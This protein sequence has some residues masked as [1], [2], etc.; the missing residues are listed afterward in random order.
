MKAKKLMQDSIRARFSAAAPT[1][2][3]HAVIQRRVAGRLTTFLDDIPQPDTILEAGCG[4]G[5]LTEMLMRVF[6]TARIDALDISEG[7]INEAR[8]R[9]PDQSRIRWIVGDVRNFQ[10]AGQY[11]LVVSSSSLH[12]AEPLIETLLSLRH[13]LAPKGIL[14]AAIMLRGTLEEL[15]SARRIIAP[16][17]APSAQLMYFHD[18]AET[19]KCAGFSIINRQEETYKAEYAS[20]IEFLQCIHD[21][22]LTGGP[23][24]RS[25]TPLSRQELAALIDEY[26]M[27]YALG[28]GGV[29]A[30]Y[31]VGYF[32]ACANNRIRHACKSRC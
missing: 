31:N 3:R 32:K 24:S 25:G 1:Y 29:H 4:S 21:Q 18:M 15:H 23:V 19:F 16:H 9:I 14:T 2:E 11:D 22:G 28:G 30:S 10:T 5:L 7:M 12:W 17:K 6:P 20:A 26:D 13:S 27:R 8:G